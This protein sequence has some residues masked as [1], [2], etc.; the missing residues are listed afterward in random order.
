MRRLGI[1]KCVS[2]YEGTEDTWKLT[3]GLGVGFIS[4]A[5]TLPTKP[6]IYHGSTE[7]E[8]PAE[9]QK[10]VCIDHQ[11]KAHPC[12][13]HPWLLLVHNVQPAGT[14]ARSKLNRI[15]SRPNVMPWQLRYCTTNCITINFMFRENF[16][17]STQVC[18]SLSHR[19]DG[20]QK[21]VVS[22][23]YGCYN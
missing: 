23:T 22:V 3:L 13:A 4:Y 11:T 15:V 6:E 16:P 20:R 12:S 8:Y 9:G 17:T 7:D 10:Y 18:N 5:H 1:H 14:D 19:N 21:G 2:T